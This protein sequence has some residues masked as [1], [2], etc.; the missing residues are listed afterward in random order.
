V[1]APWKAREPDGTDSA[2]LVE[3]AQRGDGG[4]RERVIALCTPLVLRTGSRLCGRYLQVGRDDEVSIGLAALNEAIDR[5]RRGSGASFPAFAEMV[6][7]RRLIDYFRRESARRETPFS[8]FDQADDEGEVFNP[9][10][11]A[12]ALEADRGRRADEDR[13][14]EVARFRELLAGFGISFADLVR[15]SPRHADARARA[16][17]VAKAV[18]GNPEWADLLRRQRT[19]PL[20]ELE[21]HPELGVSRKTVERQRKFIIAAALVWM[22]GLEGLRGYLE[23]D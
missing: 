13:R 14:A 16:L 15:G 18:A 21:R 8:E 6:V 7:R 23:G 11:V 22:E 1:P 9:L 12:A 10:E 4:A 2:D 19:L 20:R 3:A 17:A 5:W